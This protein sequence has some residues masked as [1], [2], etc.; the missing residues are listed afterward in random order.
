[1]CLYAIFMMV[2]TH[3]NKFHCK[4]GIREYIKRAWMIHID[5][6]EP[7][8]RVRGTARS[9]VLPTIREY[10]LSLSLSL[11]FYDYTS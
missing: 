11:H 6:E 5:I 10:T 2:V 7:K 4:G 8:K 1:M 9:H 3:R